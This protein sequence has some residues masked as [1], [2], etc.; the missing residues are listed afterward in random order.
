[1]PAFTAAAAFLVAEIGGI[2]FAAAVG[3]AGVAFTTSVVAIGLAVVTSRLINGSPDS[4]GGTAQDPGVRTQLPPQT[5]NK[6]PVVYGSANTKGVITDARLSSSGGDTN[7]LMTYVLILSEQTQTGTF[8]VGNVYWNDSLLVF[9]T[10]A[11][12]YI[13]KSSIDQA[14]DGTTSTN[15]ADLIKIR[16]YSGDA[17]NSA[18]QIFPTTNKVS[19]ISFLGESDTNYKLSGLVYAVV[20]IKYNSEKGVTGLADMTFQL[21]N[22]LKNPGL[23]WYDYMSSTR[24]GAGIDVNQIDTFSSISTVTST[25]LYSISNEIPPNQF[26]DDGITTSTQARY[27]INGVLSPGNT[28][29]DNIDRI[30][31]NCATWTSFDYVDGLWKVI[32]NRALSSLELADTFEFTDDNII[33]EVNINAT[34]LESLYNSLEVEFPNRVQR[35]QVDY[36]RGAIPTIERNPLEPDNT[37]SMRLDLVNNAIHAGRIGKLELLQS[38]VDLIATFRADHS[39]LQVES[40]DVIRLTNSVYGFEQKPFRV[41][42]TRE[43]E[44]EDGGLVTEITAL[45]YSNGVYT[46]QTLSDYAPAGG[47]G[48]PVDGSNTA[49]PAPSAPTF[50]A[51][52]PASNTPN[53]TVSTVI[54]AGSGPVDLIEWWYSNSAG[55]TYAYLT[56]EHGNFFAGQTVNDVIFNLAPGTWYIKARAASGSRS[57]YSEFSAASSALVWNPTPG[58]VNSGTISTSTFSSQIQ[59]VNTNTGVYSLALTTGTGYQTVYGDVD[60]VYNAASNSLNAGGGIVANKVM[61]SGGYPLDANGQALIATNSTQSVAMVISNYSGNMLPRVTVRGYGQNIPGGTATSNAGGTITLESS[62]GTNTAPTVNASGDTLGIIQ[63]AGY[64]GANWLSNQTTAGVTQLQP[65]GIFVQAAES[66]ANNGSATTNAGTTMGFR[67]QPVGAQLNSSSRRL[68]MG[69]TWTAGSTATNSPPILNMGMGQGSGDGAIPTLTPASGVGSFGTGSGRTNWAWNGAAHLIYGIPAQDTGPDNTTLTATNVVTFISGRRNWFSGRRD[70]LASGDTVGQ[71]NYNAQTA[72]SQTGNGSTVG[73]TSFLMLEGAGASARGTQFI[74]NTVNTGTTTLAT[75]MALRDRD[76]T[77][78]SDSHVFKDKSST[79]T[80]L[81]V[82]TSTV[83][84]AGELSVVGTAWTSF[85]PTWTSS[86]TAPALNNGTL[87]GFYKQIGKTVFV[88]VRLQIGTTTTTGTGNWRFALPVAAKDSAGVV[89]SATYLDNGTNWYMGV[90]NCEYDGDTGY[91]VPLTSASPS[92][93]VTGTVPFTWNT[94][95][96]LVFNGSYEA[97]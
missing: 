51:Q 86:G 5:S 21:Q 7:D 1:M 56:N 65:A 74:V 54:G 55:G 27:V 49:L 58:G 22:S 40:G 35:D 60:V 64:D 62:R 77:F 29:R 34:D 23:V 46:D 73:L 8:S 3:A 12:T 37:L 28:V 20:Q 50:S 89:M 52:N 26:E 96:S 68:F 25:S 24:Y 4:G 2:V 97:A 30:S 41:T 31:Q 75:R 53:F 94:G 85:T 36:F 57:R 9:G 59:I 61:S 10:G 69:Q 76:S 47:S 95:D 87:T 63:F 38:R 39:A 84:I 18:S 71:F 88:R 79:F 32:P 16:V 48:I 42:R 70:A 67:I 81:T 19:A 14:G 82:T 17:T 45:E 6:I 83:T 66:F 13:V 33:G 93:A 91:V 43:V 80:A 11:D 44:T 92:G 90:V 72:A 15:F 78:N